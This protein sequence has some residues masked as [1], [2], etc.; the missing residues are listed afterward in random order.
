MNN[1]LMVDGTTYYARARASY[2]T[3][4]GAANTTYGEVISFVYNSGTAPVVILGDVNGDGEVTAADVTAL[5]DYLLNDDSSH[6]G[7]GDQTGEGNITAADVT[8]V[9]N[10]L[11][12]GK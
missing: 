1:K 6:I 9:Y 2:N 10:I 5:Y 11:L 12:G 8:A 4:S 3:E 7:N